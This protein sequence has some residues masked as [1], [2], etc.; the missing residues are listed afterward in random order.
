MAPAQSQSAPQALSSGLPQFDLS[1]FNGTILAA[2]A[3]AGQTLLIRAVEL[4]QEMIRFAGERLEANARM[5]Q[6]LPTTT[7]WERMVEIQSEF[8]RGAA[9][10]YLNEV[11]RLTEQ[12]ARTCS[13]MWE[14]VLDSAEE[15]PEAV[16][17]AE[18]AR[19]EP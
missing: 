11:P 9:D 4:N 5:W 1:V 19:S 12:A 17:K 14:P 8:L 18:D 3:Q 13:A 15:L 16:A 2:Y 6:G 7:T 10:A